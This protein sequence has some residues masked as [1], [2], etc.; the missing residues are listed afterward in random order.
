MGLLD[1][2]TGND[3]NAST[4]GSTL[5]GLISAL[6]DAAMTQSRLRSGGQP[7]A[8]QSA[9][10]I[11]NAALRSMDD[12]AQAPQGAQAA[13]APQQSAPAQAPQ[14]ND[15]QPAGPVPASYGQIPA[16]TAG[17]A[18]SPSP[19]ESANAPAPQSGGLL[20][21]LAGVAQ[22]AASDPGQ[23]KGLLSALGDYAKGLGDKLTNMSPAASQ[24]MIATGLTMLGNNNGRNNLATLVGMGGAAGL[25]N[26]QTNI[27]NQMANRLA[28]QKQAIDL[29]NHAIDNQVK[30]QNANTE[31]FKAINQP[32]IVAP[33]SS[34]ATPGSLATG[35][36]GGNG[37][38]FQ[39]AP[40]VART[41]DIADGQGNVFTQGF[42]AYGKPVGQAQPKKLA[43][44]GELNADQQKIVN[45][46]N[47]TAASSAFGLQKSQNFIAKLTPT[48]PDPNNP[49][50]TIPNPDYTP[51]TGGV[52]ATVQNA[53]NK[54]TGSQ[55]QSQMLRNEI[56]QNIYHAQLGMWKPGIGGRLTN[57][58]VNLLRQGMPPDNASGE[59]LRSFM[60]AYAHLQEDQATHD[61][62]NAQFLT[63]NRGDS[64]PLHKDS[65]IGGVQYPAGTTLS[66]VLSRQS[67][68]QSQQAQSDG[69][70]MDRLQAQS[71]ISRA[72]AAAR[73]GDQNAQ[74]ALRSHG[75]SW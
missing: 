69:P 34:V 53:L 11:D 42:D 62:L 6:N 48:I 59:A 68:V 73:S 16:L 58:D 33:G 60:T 66:Q 8:A 52:A 45:D 20:G 27:Q 28:Q 43:F 74:T 24:A 19:A 37:M 18:D 1:A 57:T 4:Y 44:T 26:Y 47:Q 61:A 51:V 65:T 35:G 36:T 49:G 14:R 41:E 3:P 7:V 25:N 50:K 71:V 17:D 38:A 55:S 10:T 15:I 72:Q 5:R 39:A 21:S 67:P 29:Y 64:S 22:Q 40:S 54:L 32:T 30:Q 31:Q 12:Q 63:Q 9:Q 23:A 75:L 70:K 13:P 56:Q 2:I 46:A